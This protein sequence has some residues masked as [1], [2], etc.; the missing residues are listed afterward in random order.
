MK[1]NPQ[2]T[3]KATRTDL[4][5]FLAGRRY[6]DFSEGFTHPKQRKG[7]IAPK[8]DEELALFHQWLSLKKIFHTHIANERIDGRAFRSAI[9]QGMMKGWP[10]CQVFH[11]GGA[12][13]FIEMKRQ[14]WGSWKI[15]PAQMDTLAALRK[16][17]HCAEVAWGYD[18][19]IYMSKAWMRWQDNA[20]KGQANR[21]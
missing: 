5:A 1:N 8:E 11:D 10:D 2:K 13:L 18:H 14:R 21:L 4:Y 16:H 6:P 12:I 7:F 9:K 17:G 19:A 20:L 3:A 15:S